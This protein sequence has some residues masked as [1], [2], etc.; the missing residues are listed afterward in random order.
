MKIVQCSLE[1]GTT[2]QIAWLD[3]RKDLKVGCYV[4]LKDS[5]DPLMLWKV[6][7]MGKVLDEKS[8]SMQKRSESWFANDHRR[9][10][11]SRSR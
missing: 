1:H 10:I 8:M 11:P 4:T 3:W 9:P 2:S 5:E 7:S 6:I